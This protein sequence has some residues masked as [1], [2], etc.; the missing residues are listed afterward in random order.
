VSVNGR[1]VSDIAIVGARYSE[2]QGIADI[3]IVKHKVGA[4]VPLLILIKGPHRNDVTIEKLETFP[5]DTLDVKIGEP[6]KYDTVQ[7][8]PITVIIPP[9]APIGQYRSSE[10][11]AGR[12]VLKTTHPTIGTVDFRVSFAVVE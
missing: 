11:N 2:R 8:V 7:K 10:D 4:K 5:A 6:T 3:G 9:G 1:I 12:V